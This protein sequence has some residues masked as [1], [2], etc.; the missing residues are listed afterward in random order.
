VDCF[1]TTDG[2]PILNLAKPYNDEV[3]HLNPNFNTA[4]TLYKEQDPYAN[5]DPRFYA[6]I[7]Y[8]GSKRKAFWSFEESELSVENYPAGQGNRT[9]IIATWEGEPKTGINPNIRSGTATGYYIRKFL[10]PNSGRDNQPQ[11]EY[12]K[13]FRLGEI[14]LNFA[15]AAAEANHL[16]EAKAAVDEIRA[17]VGMPALPAGLSQA[18]LILRIRNERRV[19]LAL[20]G[21]RYYDVRRWTSPDGNLE[22]TDRHITSVRITRNADGTY[23]Y[24]RGPIK[25]RECYTRKFLWVPVPMNEAN[26]MQSLTGENWQN[27]GW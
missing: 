18:D 14:I 7:Y 26:I 20:E 1:E 13:E 17:R 3:T 5:R 4:N 15:E 21:F 11:N 25:E 22:K 10:H 16:A 19:E 8:N 27:P 2:Q 9:R 23:T 24:R 6:S 12:H